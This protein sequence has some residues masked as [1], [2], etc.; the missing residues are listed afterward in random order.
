M[1]LDCAGPLNE[2]GDVTLFHNL[3][4]GEDEFVNE[5][6]LE[7]L[8]RVELVVVVLDASLVVFTNLL[9]QIKATSVLDEWQLSLF[10]GKHLQIFLDEHI[11]CP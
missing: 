5:L 3:L 11:H 10:D 1:C 8:A 7:Q 2:S 6:E 4:S 9:L